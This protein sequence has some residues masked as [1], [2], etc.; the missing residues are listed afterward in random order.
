MFTQLSSACH[1]TH[2][3]RS[4]SSCVALIDQVL[5][6]GVSIQQLWYRN[7]HQLSVCSTKTNIK[8]FDKA[9]GILSRVI[10]QMA[11][12][13]NNSNSTTMAPAPGQ[14]IPQVDAET[15]IETWLTC[16]MV[17]TWEHIWIVEEEE[18]EEENP[19]AF[20]LQ[21][22]DTDSV[23]PKQ[24]TPERPELS[25]SRSQTKSGTSNCAS[26]YS[27]STIRS[28]HMSAERDHLPASSICSSVG[29]LNLRISVKNPDQARDQAQ[30]TPHRYK[31]GRI[32]N[33][34]LGPS[35]RTNDYLTDN[36]DQKSATL[37][38]SPLLDSST[39][40]CSVNSSCKA[41]KVN[42]VYELN[43][44]KSCSASTFTGSKS[45]SRLSK[46]PPL[47][48]SYSPSPVGDKDI[49]NRKGILQHASIGMRLIHN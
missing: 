14:R 4:P 33:L 29:Y 20:P 8:L 38:S 44:D 49:W 35:L 28:N 26:L 27:D 2:S 22:M 37:S 41:G 46:P 30:D 39:H 40:R 19:T 43:I 5:P 16:D 11:C 25:L 17:S 18:E 12:Q 31:T 3:P 7:S 9:A 6:L 13:I 45:E 36:I 15:E 47:L 23:S 42:N 21:A 34:R 48:L 10:V 32:G 24:Q 1:Q